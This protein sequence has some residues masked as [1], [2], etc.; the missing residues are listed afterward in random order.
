[1]EIGDYVAP[2]KRGL[3]LRSGSQSYTYAVVI[4]LNPF[5]IVSPKADMRWEST[6][7]IIDFDVI[8]RA[9]DETISKCMKRI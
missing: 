6:V 1:M 3:Y 5:V 7:S 2:N 8:G 4:S 9:D